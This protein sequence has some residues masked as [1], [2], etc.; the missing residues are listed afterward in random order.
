MRFFVNLNFKAEKSMS[1]C[2]MFIDALILGE[3]GRKKKRSCYLITKKYTKSSIIDET[4]ELS[5]STF[6]EHAHNE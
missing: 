6:S 5:R 3:G 1:P 4:K 2:K